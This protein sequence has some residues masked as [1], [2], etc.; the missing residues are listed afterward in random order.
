[1]SLSIYLQQKTAL[2]TKSKPYKC[3]PHTCKQARERE[4]DRTIISITSL[5]YGAYSLVFAFGHHHHH[6]IDYTLYTNNC[7]NRILENSEWK[8]LQDAGK[9]MIS[10]CFRLLEY[11][12][13]Y[14]D[15]YF[16]CFCL[17][18]FFFSHTGY[19]APGFL[20]NISKF[21][22]TQWNSLGSCCCCCE[23]EKCYELLK[24]IFPCRV[25]EAKKKI[26][27]L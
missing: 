19:W 14:E 8:L 10:F 4:R 13:L 22:V 7:R 21:L 9:L 6:H 5:P 20:T 26:F 1:M 2:C 15:S 11:K 12:R 24:F 18:F 25:Q 16:K 17:A 3:A 23:K 27:F